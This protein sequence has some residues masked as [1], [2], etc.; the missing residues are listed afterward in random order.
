[1]EVP[2]LTPELCE[3]LIA[4]AEAQAAG[5]TVAE[6]EADR[7]AGLAAILKAIAQVRGS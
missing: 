2:K 5:R 6:L 3:K 4:G 7:D 1:M